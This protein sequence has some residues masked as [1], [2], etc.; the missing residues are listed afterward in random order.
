MAIAKKISDTLDKGSLIV[1]IFKK[2]ADLREKWGADN[3][4]D[5]T[6][7]NPSA[8]PPPQMTAILHELIDEKIDR[9]HGY[10][11]TAGLPQARAAIADQVSRQQNRQLGAEHIVLCCGAGGGINL[12]LGS[13]INPGDTIITL[14]PRFLSYPG[15]IGNFG[16]IEKMAALNE[17]Y[18]INYS[19][20]DNVI[21]SGCAAIIV[22]SP[23]NPAGYLFSAE[24]IA[25]LGRFLKQKSRQVG[26]VIYLIAD[27]PYRE[28]VFDGEQTAAV[29]PHYD[30]AVIINSCSKSHSL[31]G[32]RIGWCAINPQ[33]E[34]ADRLVAAC[35]NLQ[36]ALGYT[37]APA[38]MQR[39]LARGADLTVDSSIY[40][41]KRD[42]VCSGLHRI[43]YQFNKP[44]GAFYLFV[45]VPG[46]LD[47]DGFIDILTKEKILVIP[48]VPFGARGYFR[49]SFCV[50]DSTIENS[51]PAF[52]RAFAAAN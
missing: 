39:A 22:N 5:Y 40:Q 47:E 41:R 37:N 28:I 31:A 15:Y 49:L 6:I 48:G 36:L 33:A 38:L 19:A 9:K 18:S 44:A 45:K 12:V 16:G 27:E 25:C 34:Q 4:Y 29:F 10:T 8:D 17:D 51:L 26:R 11:M 52:E 13:L 46:G 2:G 30:H 43:G 1:E 24:E 23:N 50:S 14:A 42:S 7:G 3:I 21:D 32:E 35:L 20:L